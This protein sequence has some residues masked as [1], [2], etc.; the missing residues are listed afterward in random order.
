MILKLTCNLLC[1][2]KGLEKRI[3]LNSVSVDILLNLTCT[4]LSYFSFSLFRHI[5]VQ[6]KIKNSSL[7]FKFKECSET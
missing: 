1:L 6:K 5:V 3:R 2:E 7:L 4:L